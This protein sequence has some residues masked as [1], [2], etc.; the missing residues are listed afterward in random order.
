MVHPCSR[1]LCLHNAGADLPYA[2]GCHV[3]LLR[4]EILLIMFIYLKARNQNK[5]KLDK[6]TLLDM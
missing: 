6:M 3:T 2:K 4:Q 1:N 5:D